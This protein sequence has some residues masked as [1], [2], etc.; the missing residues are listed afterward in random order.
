MMRRDGYVT[1]AKPKP[2]P[3]GF[4]DDVPEAD[5]HAD[6][7]S[8]SV[9]GAKLMLK[10]PALF[11]WQQDHPVHK[12]VFDFGSA[13]H[14]L[15]LGV[16]QD[17]ASVAAPDWR[18]KV[19]QERRDAL[20]E[21]GFIPLLQKD[22]DRVVAMAYELKQH[23]LA[24]RLLSDGKA[25]VSAYA[26]H[27]P[28]GVTRRGRFD[29][30]GTT[31]LSDY[32]TAATAEPAAFV[33]AAVNYGYHMQHAWYLDLARDLGHPAKAFAFIVQEKEP[34]YLVTVIELPPELVDVGRARNTR[35]LE[36]FR[37]CTETDRW[38][39]Y[40]PDDQFAQPDA[41]SWALR[42]DAS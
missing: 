14:R 34:P 12:D 39:G 31:I 32:K 29:W 35:A 5:Y 26:E 30:L 24:M 10:A 41:P 1:A 6:Q 16:G 7:T 37:D 19:A 20:R 13:A 17:I 27:E 22:Y 21:N 33:R 4:L 18:T 15:V 25:E 2:S 36:R 3:A 11:R 42:E 8:L 40:V 23:R 38:P 28:T 9:S